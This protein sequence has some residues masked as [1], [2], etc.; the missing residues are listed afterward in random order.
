MQDYQVSS[1][2]RPWILHGRTADLGWVKDYH[3]T[4]NSRY[5]S[6][7]L[8]GRPHLTAPPPLQAIPAGQSQDQDQ[9]VTHQGPYGPGLKRYTS[10]PRDKVQSRISKYPFF[11]KQ[12]SPRFSRRFITNVEPNPKSKRNVRGKGMKKKKS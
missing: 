4:T 2:A 9:A 7:S 8:L 10:R 5:Q 11:L 12:E 1:T 3:H 6:S